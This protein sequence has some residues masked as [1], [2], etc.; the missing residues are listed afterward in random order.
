MSS[1]KYSCKCSDSKPRIPILHGPHSY[2]TSETAKLDKALDQLVDSAWDDVDEEAD[3]LLACFLGNLKKAN[4]VHSEADLSDILKDHAAPQ[5]SNSIITGLRG[6]ERQTCHCREVVHRVSIVLNWGLAELHCNKEP[7]E[8]RLLEVLHQLEP[9]AEMCAKY[10]AWNSFLQRLWDFSVE[11]EKVKLTAKLV[12]VYPDAINQALENLLSSDAADVDSLLDN[13][14]FN[15]VVTLVTIPEVFQ[16]VSL[17][18]AQRDSV[19]PDKAQMLLTAILKTLKSNVSKSR[20]L[21]LYPDTIRS[22]AAILYEAIKPDDP[23][24]TAL[25]DQVKRDNFLEFTVLVTHFP[26]FLHLK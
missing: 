18:L 20:F 6:Y 7:N 13:E 25:L 10:N 2:D 15:S 3:E 4:Y 14:S 17:Q 8:Q 26:M 9:F 1:F 12:S 23:L 16:H 5:D 21:A 22:I 11:S 24:L 19:C